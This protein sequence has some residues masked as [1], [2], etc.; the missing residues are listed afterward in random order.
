MKQSRAKREFQ[1]KG[2]VVLKGLLNAAEVRHYKAEMEALSG[3]QNSQMRKS[4]KLGQ[5]GLDSAWS[6]PDGVT[7]HQPLILL[8][9]YLNHAVSYIATPLC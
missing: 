5:R 8:L 1:E 2:F 6:Q 3:I 4:H 9:L 7:K